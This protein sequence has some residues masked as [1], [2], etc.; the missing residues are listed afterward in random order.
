[1]IT[2]VVAAGT[3]NE[4]G[5][6]NELLWHLPNDLKHFKKLTTGHPVVMGRKTFESIGKPLPHRT[7]IVLTRNK[8]W[9]QEGILIVNTLKEAIK[10]AKK[11]DENIFVIGGGKVFEQCM[12]IADRIEMTRVAAELDADVYFPEIDLKEWREIKEESFSK[13]EK[14]P[15]DYCFQT[16][17]KVSM[18]KS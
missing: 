8:D 4:I 2:L 14:N 18:T 17:E 11:I 5:K 10:F 1:M 13:D 9:L 15:Y 6:G 12:E 7:N 16:F 3:R